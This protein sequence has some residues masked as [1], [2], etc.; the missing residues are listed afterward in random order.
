VYEREGMSDSVID[1]EKQGVGREEGDL[2]F[3]ITEP[4]SGN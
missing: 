2:N 1:R 4:F 3:W